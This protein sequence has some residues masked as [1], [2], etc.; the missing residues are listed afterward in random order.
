MDGGVGRR[1]NGDDRGWY[2]TVGAAYAF[3]VPGLMRLGR[4]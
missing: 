4:R 2:V 3:G 1:L